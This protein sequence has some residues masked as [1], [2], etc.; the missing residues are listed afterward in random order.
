MK[1]LIVFIII[2]LLGINCSITKSKN[3]ERTMI[4]TIYNGS[5]TPIIAKWNDY[6][7][8][9]PKESIETNFFK[10]DYIIQSWLIN[11]YIYKIGKLNNTGNH[12]VIGW[13]NQ[14]NYDLWLYNETNMQSDEYFKTGDIFILLAKFLPKKEFFVFPDNYK[15]DIEYNLYKEYLGLWKP[16]CVLGN[17][18]D[19]KLPKLNC[20]RKLI[21]SGSKFKINQ[22][23]IF[24]DL[25]P[26]N[27]NTKK[28]MNEGE[29]DD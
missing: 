21:F 9:K 25:K 4:Y 18:I 13:T 27:K 24:Y 6:S 26:I 5:I 7:V 3:Y 16:N 11:S 2:Y 20:T 12:L 15:L 17:D 8:I 1:Y 22:N 14:Y 28:K 10:I 29:K 23:D 19:S